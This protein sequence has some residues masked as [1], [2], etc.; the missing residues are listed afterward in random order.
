MPANFPFTAII[1][2]LHYVNLLLHA[3]ADAL[4]ALIRYSFQRSLG[5]AIG[6][7]I[8]GTIFQNR[9]THWLAHSTPSP[10]PSAIA[11]NLLGYIRIL[12]ALPPSEAAF[13]AAVRVAIA[14]THRNVA[15]VG[16]AVTVC[17]LLLMVALKGANVGGA[18]ASKHR[19]EQAGRPQGD[20]EMVSSAGEK[21]VGEQATEAVELMRERNDDDKH[22]YR[23]VQ[24]GGEDGQEREVNTLLGRD[25]GMYDDIAGSP[26]S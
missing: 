23:Q 18:L 3:N 9:L 6:V 17:A 8:I 16:T 4:L 1:Y 21:Q 2:P 25:S 15:E 7:S 11:T 14:Q 5:L 12:N 19:F 26:A 20:L 22:A 24:S 13:A 10:L